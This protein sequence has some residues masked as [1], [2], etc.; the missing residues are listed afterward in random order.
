MKA[1]GNSSILQR[2]ESNSE[3]FMKSLYRRHLKSLKSFRAFYFKINN[4]FSW[5]FLNLMCSHCLL[6][7]TRK[8]LLAYWLEED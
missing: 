5:S 6:L 2:V 7:A 1:L 3:N 4:T 8:I